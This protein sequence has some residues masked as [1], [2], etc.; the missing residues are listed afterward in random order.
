MSVIEDYVR[1]TTMKK[2]SKYC[3]NG[4]FEHLLF[5]SFV[6]FENFLLSRR[7]PFVVLDMNIYADK[8]KTLHAAVSTDE[9]ASTGS[10][11][12]NMPALKGREDKPSLSMLLPLAA[13]L[14]A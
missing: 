14:G 3:G 7:V 2:S 6:H 10:L 8:D 11:C 13:C 12:P 5:L 9:H 1:E 4:S